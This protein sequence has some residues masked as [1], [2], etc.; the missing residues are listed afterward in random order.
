MKRFKNKLDDYFKEQFINYA[1]HE[2]RIRF[3]LDSNIIEHK[4]GMVELQLKPKHYNK[5][6]TIFEFHKGDSLNHLI[7]L[8]EVET[9]FIDK[10]IKEIDKN[11]LWRK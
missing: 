10:R 5:F 9:D 2:V 6:T 4:N 11:D 1:F 7:S 8:R 3:N